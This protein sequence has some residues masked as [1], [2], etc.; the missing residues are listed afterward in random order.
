MTNFQIEAAA[1]SSIGNRAENQDRLYYKIDTVDGQNCG[2]FCVADGM[3]GLAD[4]H[5]AAVAAVEGLGKWWENLPKILSSGYILEQLQNLFHDIN[6]QILQMANKSGTT[7][8]VLLIVGNTY[9]IAHSGDSRIYM[10]KKS[11]N[12]AALRQLTED[13][14]WQ[15]EQLKKAELTAA[16]IAANPLKNRITSCLGVYENP[17]LFTNFGRLSR[18]TI[19]ILCSDGL[20]RAVSDKEFAKTAKRKAASEK[21]AAK[22]LYKAALN[23]VSDNAS[24]LTVTCRKRK[25]K[26]KTPGFFRF[27]GRG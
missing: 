2:L 16:Q 23:G 4:G 11:F 20:Y 1:L 3:G 19:F 17:K 27:W 21:L 5:L 14:S 26:G 13:H 12:K 25:L 6:R 15:A 7:L 10:I 9:Y 18:S 24:I 22:Y 8:S